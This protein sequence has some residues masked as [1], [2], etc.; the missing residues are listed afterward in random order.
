MPRRKK[1]AEFTVLTVLAVLL[2]SLGMLPAVAADRDSLASTAAPAF[3]CWFWSAAE[4]EPEGYRPFLDLVGQ[5]AAFDR[6]TTSLRVAGHEV[7][8]AST[9]DQIR[10]AA[11]YAEQSRDEAGDGFGRAAGPSRASSARTR[12]N[13]RRCCASAKWNCRRPAKST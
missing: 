6:L 8:E 9:H 2:A 5:H 13:S 10:R 3:G 7:T 4:F 12:M 1:L 11:E